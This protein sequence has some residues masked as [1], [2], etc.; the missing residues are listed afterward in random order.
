MTRL[1]D[2]FFMKL[3]YFKG[4]NKLTKLLFIIFLSL[5]AS[6]SAA[7][8]LDDSDWEREQEENRYLHIVSFLPSRFLIGSSEVE[9]EPEKIHHG[10]QLINK[11]VSIGQIYISKSTS[12]DFPIKCPNSLIVH[13]SL[14]Y[15]QDNITKCIEGGYLNYDTSLSLSK[16][17]ATVFISGSHPNTN[18]R[19][20]FDWERGGAKKEAL[21]YFLNSEALKLKHNIPQLSIH[22][23]TREDS[24]TKEHTE[25]HFTDLF[26]SG[27]ATPIL[28][29]LLQKATSSRSSEDEPNEEEEHS[30]PKQKKVKSPLKLALLFDLGSYYFIC[31][32]TRDKERESCRSL[33]FGIANGS[34]QI[35]R[36][37]LKEKVDK[38]L[39][40]VEL[41]VRELRLQGYPPIEDMKIFFRFSFAISPNNFKNPNLLINQPI[42]LKGEKSVI[43]AHF[44][45]PGI[46][47]SEI[48]SNFI[49]FYLC[50]TQRDG[51]FEQQE[52]TEKNKEI[53]EWLRRIKDFSENY[54]VKEEVYFY[55]SRKEQ[56]RSLLES[57]EETDKIKKKNRLRRIDTF[58]DSLKKT[59]YKCDCKKL[60][61]CGLER[62]IPK[63]PKRPNKKE[64]QAL[65]AYDKKKQLIE[66]Q[67][68]QLYSMWE[69]RH[70]GKEVKVKSI[71]NKRYEIYIDKEK[72]DYASLR[73][74]KLVPILRGDKETELKMYIEWIFFP[75]EENKW[76]SL[77]ETLLGSD[78]TLLP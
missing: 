34:D 47:N 55:K 30:E 64:K 20:S 4:H 57:I 36:P 26:F 72:V 65:E 19:Y 40:N 5:F 61:T 46:E 59:E 1:I 71:H 50:K 49:E 7:M 73:R 63:N 60:I 3:P 44:P 35:K 10:L 39:K 14:L 27:S 25:E 12:P 13:L 52:P 24:I 38:Y 31:K 17:K 68:P 70:E 43:S 21:T 66:Q 33:L 45:L 76:Y 18:N 6:L 42:F 67:P 9:C 53:L 22:T 23:T 56:A 2:C 51:L 11:L 28:E 74:G 78:A 62:P 77:E 41:W 8:Q 75:E 29:G 16:D 37:T 69:G 54:G 32:E 48:F 58:L 15:S